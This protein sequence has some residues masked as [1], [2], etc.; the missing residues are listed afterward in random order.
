MISRTKNTKIR[1]AITRSG[2]QSLRD[3][4]RGA[5]VDEPLSFLTFYGVK[6]VAPKVDLRELAFLR[7]KEGKTER[8]LA[9]Y[10]GCSKTSIHNLLVGLRRK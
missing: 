6:W 2:S 8:E 9:Q 1:C 10:F 5:K 4:A 7:F 3:G